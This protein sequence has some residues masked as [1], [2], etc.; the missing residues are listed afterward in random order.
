VP[1]LRLALL[2][3][4]ALSGCR[5]AR[6]PGESLGEF[7]IAGALSSSTCA[8]G[9][10]AP[11]TLAFRVELRR[12]PGSSYGYWKLPD[13]ALVSGTLGADGAFRFEQRTLYPVLAPDPETDNP[14]C[15]LERTE[16]VQGEVSSDASDAAIDAPLL[17]TTNI[18]LSPQAGTFCAPLLA[19]YG[20]PFPEL[21][22]A[23]E[24]E[25]EGQRPA[26]P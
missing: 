2:S 18:T 23:I 8:S 1:L 14:G 21:P 10:P 3:C 19:V 5:P 17:G 16:V 13:T 24:Y 4:L 25:L 22:C 9:Y 15:A 6:L 11:P 20:G 26:T 7:V 12:E